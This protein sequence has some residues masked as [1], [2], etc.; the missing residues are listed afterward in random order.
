MDAV[1]AMFRP[2]ETM[3]HA[4]EPRPTQSER[5]ACFS[6]TTTPEGAPP[7]RSFPPTRAARPAR[8]RGV[9]F[10]GRWRGR[11]G[12]WLANGACVALVA[13]SIA[14]TAHFAEPAFE[15]VAMN[16]NVGPG[17]LASAT[18]PPSLLLAP[19]H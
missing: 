4:S 12:R 19:S 16:A 5:R 3:Q 2:E 6:P 11:L 13:L 10:L 1:T 8:S 18:R 14:A 9:F 7:A 15:A 17:L